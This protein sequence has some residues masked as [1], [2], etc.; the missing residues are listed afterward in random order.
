MNN[1]LRR[2]PAQ[3][4]SIVTTG[5]LLLSIFTI[6]TGFADVTH[7]ILPLLTLASATALRYAT[8]YHQYS[9]SKYRIYLTVP[10]SIIFLLLAARAINSIFS[11]ISI[12]KV[13]RLLEQESFDLGSSSFLPNWWIG[14]I[15][16]VAG[17][18]IVIGIVN[19]RDSSPYPIPS[20][21]R[22]TAISPVYFG[23][24]CSFFGLW[25][26]LFAGFSI[27]RIIVIA[28]IFEELLKFGVALLVGSTLFGRSLAARIGVGLVVGASFGLIEHATTYPTESDLYYLSRTVFH[29]ATTVLSITS[30]TLFESRNKIRLQWIAPVYSMLFHFIYNTFV[31]L[32]SVI[33]ILVFNSQDTFIPVIGSSIIILITAVLVVIGILY[34]SILVTTHRPLEQFLSDF[35]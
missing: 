15:L 6:H 26:V 22:A 23:L 5:L 10:L 25:A 16:V 20:E 7:I 27:Q 12:N 28:P 9:K 29:S 2:V 31:V 21:I 18:L 34:T 13:D 33:S 19:S 35:V 1:L 17:S 4:V 32:V 24:A 3:I 14:I 8:I 30:Y 11:K